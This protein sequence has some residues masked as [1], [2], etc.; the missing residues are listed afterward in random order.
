[1]QLGHLVASLATATASLLFIREIFITARR[2]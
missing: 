1:M 2:V